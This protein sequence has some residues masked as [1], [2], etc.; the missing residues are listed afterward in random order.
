[1]DVA[2]ATVTVISLT[3]A[4]AMGVVTWRLVR[5]ERRRSDARVA[6]LMAELER[7]HRVGSAGQIQLSRLGL[8]GLHAIPESWKEE[9]R[10]GY[11]TSRSVSG[12]VIKR[13]A[14]FY[15]K[16]NHDRT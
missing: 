16:L 6:T 5:E 10:R 2:L 4:L 7:S 14:L 12:E 1:M 13:P 9:V 3:M 8:D 11:P 15:K